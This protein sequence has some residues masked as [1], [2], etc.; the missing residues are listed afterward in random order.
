MQ[1]P[2][3]LACAFVAALSASHALAQAP[4]QSGP[5]NPAIKTDSRNNSSMPVKGA[6]SFTE[7]EAKSRVTGQG[8]SDVGTLHKDSNGVW[9]GVASKDGKP[10]HV[11]VDFQGNVNAD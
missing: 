4:A 3:F 7:S 11:S 5:Q 8:Y 2:A 10:V 9:R 1:N 6:N